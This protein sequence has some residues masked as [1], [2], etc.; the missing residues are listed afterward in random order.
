[1][2]ALLFKVAPN[3]P[4]TLVTVAVLLAAT[5]VLAAWIPAHRA[6]NADPVSALRGD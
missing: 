6:S 5:S 1:M 2:A 4:V 3:D